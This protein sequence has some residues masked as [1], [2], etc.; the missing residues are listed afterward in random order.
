VEVAHFRNVLTF[1]IAASA[2]GRQVA[3][4]STYNTYLADGLG[5]VRRDGTSV[6]SDGTVIEP[7]YSM[8]LKSAVINGKP[9]G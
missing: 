4:T 9:F 7:A 2:S 8:V 3:A 1:T 5:E 6:V